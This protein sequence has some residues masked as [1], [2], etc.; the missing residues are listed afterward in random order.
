MLL[1]YPSLF[2]L[3]HLDTLPYLG[4]VRKDLLV[5]PVVEVEMRIQG[6]YEVVARV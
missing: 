6:A 2:V 3:L 1:A 5:G 4:V